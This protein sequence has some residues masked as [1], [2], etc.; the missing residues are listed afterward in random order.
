MVLFFKIFFFFFIGNLLLGSVISVLAI[1]PN[2]PCPADPTL[3]CENPNTTIFSSQNI[4]GSTV[5]NPDT[6]AFYKSQF[7]VGE[8]P[9]GTGT[10]PPNATG[11]GFIEDVQEFFGQF[12]FLNIGEMIRFLSFINPFYTF[13]VMEHMLEVV[14]MSCD[15]TIMLIAFKSIFFLLGVLAFVFIIFK[16]DVI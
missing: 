13:D 9:N 6:E 15:L 3:G 1:D 12:D 10:G 2:L 11:T 5:S 4:T 14:C 7:P 16:I 8:G